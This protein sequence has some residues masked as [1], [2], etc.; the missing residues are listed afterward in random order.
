VAAVS[1]AQRRLRGRSNTQSGASDD[2]ETHERLLN[3][4]THLFAARGFAKVTVRDICRTARANVAAVNYH[5]G[6]KAGLY[7]AV[8]RVAIRIMQGTTEAARQ[9]GDNRSPD[10]Q[11]EAYVTIFLHRV[12]AHSRDSWIHQLMMREL[13]DPT[14]ALD[15]VAEEVIQPRLAYLT[16]IIIKLLGCPEDDPR[17][18]RCLLSVNAQVL[19]LLDHPVAARLRFG[20]SPAPRGIDELARHITCFSLAG[21]RAI[22]TT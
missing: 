10:Q 5:F 20:P 13:S 17:V 15:M 8:L 12:A 7:D 2:P 3:A 18:A 22:A 4:A 1:V 21:I 16:S 19:A 11:L 6:G 14:H 9:A